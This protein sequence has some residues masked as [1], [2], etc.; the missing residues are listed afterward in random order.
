MAH[1]AAQGWHPVGWT[2][3]AGDGLCRGNA[4]REMEC[5]L[6]GVRPGAILL[7]HQGGRGKSERVVALRYLVHRLQQEGWQA[8]VPGADAL[9]FSFSHSLR[10]AGNA[11]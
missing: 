7:M 5:L 10:R 9:R 2:V 6:A 11:K 3:A 1:C 4:R 8:V